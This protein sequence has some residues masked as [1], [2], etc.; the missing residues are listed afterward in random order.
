MLLS[1]QVYTKLSRPEELLKFII[2][3]GDKWAFPD[4]RIAVQIKLTIA[5]SKRHFCE[6][7][8]I[9]TYSRASIV[10]ARLIDPSTAECGEK[11]Q[12]END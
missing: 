3:Y 4:I 1:S 10:H 5:N 6:L 12:T 8:L 9:L 2:Q 7:K 11:E